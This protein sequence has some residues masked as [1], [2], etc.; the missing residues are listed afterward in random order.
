MSATGGVL[1]S[2]TH[3]LTQADFL[4]F[5]VH[6]FSQLDAYRTDTLP[7]SQEVAT[8]CDSKLSSPEDTLL[9][10]ESFM[11]SLPGAFSAECGVVMRGLEWC[12]HGES[13]DRQD[14]P[15]PK[16]KPEPKPKAKPRFTSSSTTTVRKLTTLGEALEDIAEPKPKPAPKS[17][18][19]SF[20]QRCWSGK[21]SSGLY[22]GV[23]LEENG[24][25]IGL[26]EEVGSSGGMI[27]PAAMFLLS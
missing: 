15:K 20:Q 26:S 11:D 2:Q 24:E 5:P 6:L 13:E 23:L 21:F 27:V 22:D 4:C 12:G 19:L 18:P 17:K 1:K 16:P 14:K 10:L 9:C 3:V 25:M 7:C 8:F